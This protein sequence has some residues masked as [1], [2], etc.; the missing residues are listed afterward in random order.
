MAKKII[1][2]EVDKEVILE[3]LGIID[4]NQGKFEI[5]SKPTF[6]VFHSYCDAIK[7]PNTLANL[8][9][10]FRLICLFASILQCY[11]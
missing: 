8:A 6:K 11:P 9:N 1:V 4:A 2:K 3:G 10:D 5:R 7:A